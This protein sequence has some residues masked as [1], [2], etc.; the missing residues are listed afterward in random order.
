MQAMLTDMINQHRRRPEFRDIPILFCPENAP[1]PMGGMLAHLIR[2]AAQPFLTMREYGPNRAAG[3]PKDEKKTMTMAL[4][5]IERVRSKKLRFMDQMIGGEEMRKYLVTQMAEF[6]CKIKAKQEDPFFKT[7]YTWAGAKE[8]DLIDSTMMLPFWWKWF[9]ESDFEGYSLF[10][11][12][13][14]KIK[15]V[16]I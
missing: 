2:K 5:L 10:K 3:V 7:K 15:R 9:W 11:H 13:V 8:D 16:T 14:L 1:G 6:S 4:Q 12:H